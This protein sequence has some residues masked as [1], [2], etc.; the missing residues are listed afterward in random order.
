MH[1]QLRKSN[2]YG[3]KCDLRVGNIAQCGAAC[4]V[5]TVGKCL[6]RNVY[7]LADILEHSGRKCRLCSISGWRY[8]LMTI[9]SFKIR[10]VD[11]IRF[12]LYGLDELH[13]HCP[14]RS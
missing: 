12:Y 14:Q 1:C 13:G 9:P 10:A 8:I 6:I 7:L 11:R 4:H 5:G 2:I 3:I